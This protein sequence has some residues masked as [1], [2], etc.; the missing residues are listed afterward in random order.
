[1][2]LTSF[3][4]VLTNCYKSSL[5]YNLFSR[6]LSN[7]IKK[8]LTLFNLLKLKFCNRSRFCYISKFCSDR[9]N[10]DT[11]INYPNE[12]DDS[13]RL[14]TNKNRSK[15]L[16]RAP[17]FIVLEIMLYTILNLF[18]LSSSSYAKEC[19]GQFVNPITDINW[20]CL[21]PITLGSI[22]IFPGKLAD[23]KNPS[24]PVCVCPRE[25][26]GGVPLPG[27]VSGFFEPVR[28]V[29]VSAEPY[30]FV[31]MG[32]LNINM[33]MNRHQG[34]RAKAASAKTSAWYVH[35][36]IYPIIYILELFTDFIC[37][38][39]ASYDALWLTELDPSGNDDEL[40]L[41]LNPDAFLF[42]NLISQS[43]CA[44]DCLSASSKLPIDSLYWCS[45]C[46]GS[47]FPMNANVNAHIGGVQASVNAVSKVTAKL[48]RQLM[49]HDTAADNI[50]DI[51]KKKLAP[52][53][54]KSHYRYQMTNPDPSECQP[55]GRTTTIWESNKEI[56]LV[57]EDF[58]YL[59]WRKRNCCIL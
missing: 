30:C 6:L 59:I 37:M 32:G 20:S 14:D 26:L 5:V 53:M 17:V 45:G 39:E 8:V 36:Y 4:N 31:N 43:A 25:S 10:T 13:Y 42:N 9:N 19:T 33:G 3:F 49:A 15:S 38:E 54:K 23:T 29:D 24:S 51:C 22:E 18:T 40:A 12:N 28:L 16:R 48:H 34:G 57:G 1:M 35:Y 2:K 50:K 55:F 58:G 56:P 11:N 41:I 47:M 46:Q 52:L 44:A 27:I 7:R 21:F